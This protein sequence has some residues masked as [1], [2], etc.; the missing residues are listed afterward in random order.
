[1]SKKVVVDSK[2][3]LTLVALIILATVGSAYATYVM[4]GKQVASNFTSETKDVVQV[5]R[6]IGP[7]YSAGEFIV[8]LNTPSNQIRFI[9][10]E[11]V[12]ELNDK[13][14]LAELEKRHPQVR[15][16]I[17]SLLRTRTMESLN[18]PDGIE[19]LRFEIIQNINDLLAKGRV[20]DVYFID[21]VIQ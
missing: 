17:I 1:M 5:Q 12:L 3:F 11:I 14:A 18:K 13:G 2:F 7:T 10:S 8:N 9:R 21:L 20:L 15:D 19:V 4:F 16:R 6:D